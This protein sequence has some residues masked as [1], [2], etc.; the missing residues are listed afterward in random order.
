M[1]WV[2]AWWALEGQTMLTMVLVALIF[3]RVWS[4]R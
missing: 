2:G 3:A 1:N 4:R